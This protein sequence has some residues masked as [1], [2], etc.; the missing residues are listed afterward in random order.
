MLWGYSITL[1][2][3]SRQQFPVK[4]IIEQK[5]VENVESFKCLSSVLTNDGRCAC[6][7]KSRIAIRAVG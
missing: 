5:E 3:N 4:I 2:R 7:I 1:M 6:E